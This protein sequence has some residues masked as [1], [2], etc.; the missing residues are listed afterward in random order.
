MKI[1]QINTERTWR[2]G[3]RQ[4]LFTLQG[5]KEAG[6]DVGILCRSGFPMEEA[7]LKLGVTVHAVKSQVEAAKFLAFEAKEYDIFHPQTGKGHSLAAYMKPFH[8]KPILYTRRVNF[9]Q[10]GFLSRQKYKLTDQTVAI[11]RA[12]RDTLNNE[13]VEGVEV[14]SSAI[15]KRELNQKRSEDLLGKYRS[16]G[17]TI[18]ATVGDMVPQ[19]DPV[20][21][22]KTINSLRKRRS[23][24]VFIHFGNHEMGS[25]V[26]PLI[27]KYNLEE[28]Y[29]T[30]GHL[31][32]VEDYFSMFDIF[33]ITS[34]ET[35]GLCSSVYDAF[36]YKVPIVST[37]TGGMF[38]SVAD[39]GLTCGPREPECLANHI[40]TLIDDRELGKRMTEKA[41]QWAVENVS[42]GSIT[43]KYIDL[44]KKLLS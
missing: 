23:D 19:K 15:Q 42:I 24:F 28:F 5:L 13:R 40:S 44:Y 18:I 6:V 12:I 7:A 43:Q 10:T 22:V 36:I 41:Y 38:D 25:Q 9:T 8:K 4:T 17:K 31:A 26:F 16:E 11:S 20:T 33:L 14:I 34:N 30:P 35:E 27:S 29:I 21:T 37:L 2:G 32:N 3:E 1:L 39:R